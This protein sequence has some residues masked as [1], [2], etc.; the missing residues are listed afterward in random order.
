MRNKTRLLFGSYLTQVAQL[1]GVDDA[2]VKFDVSPSVEQALEAKI[3]E[4]SEFLSAINIVPVSQQSGQKVGVGAT[5]PLAS[6]TNTAA[7][8]RRKPRSATGT[9]A[10]GYFCKKTDFDS[11]IPYSRLDA[12]SH[13]PEFQ[14]LVRDAVVKQQGRDRIMIGFNGVEAADETDAD[15]NPLLQDVNVGWLE[16]VRKNAPLRVL[17]SGDLAAA[18]TKA[19]YIAPDVEA[20]N[21]DAT[22]K[23]TAKVDYNTLDALGLD[24][25]ELLDPWNRSDTDLVV[26][27]GWALMKDKNLAMLNAMG[28]KA[29]ELEAAS[30]IL[31]LPMQI[32]GKQ[33]I[34]VPYFPE[35]SLAVTS[36]D[37][38]S[39]YVQDETRRR[40][41]KDEPAADQVENYESVN[42]DYVVEDYGRFALV[43]NIVLGTKPA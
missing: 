13:K 32:A 28:V 2:T 8:N 37:N 20:V 1:N 24:A 31:T 15:E 14:T 6:R 4:S 19:I 36:L 7:G 41:I 16:K 17:A 18:G 22:N 38:L 34:I 43:E 5:R 11:A 25:L 30:R 39:I 40:Q 23:A 9:E 21:A 26:I 29:T 3:Q 12:W 27:V 42:E 10:D 35:T 33:A